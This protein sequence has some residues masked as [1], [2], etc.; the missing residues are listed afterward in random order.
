M[1]PVS[2]TARERAAATHA[3]AEATPAGPET[4]GPGAAGVELHPV[5]CRL[6]DAL[7]R[8]LL[9][10]TL[11]RIPSNPAAPTGDVD[12]LVA[13]ADAAALRDVA[14]EHGFVP[15]PGW[16]SSPDLILVCYDRPSDR[17]LLLD[18]STAVSFRSPPSWRI[19]GAAEQVLGRR[20]RLDGMT[21]PD[22]GDAFWLLLLHC[23]L[24]KGRVA[25]GH[26]PR[27]QSLA[28]AGLESPLGPALCSAAGPRFEPAVF[29]AAVRSGEW[30]AI[31]ALGSKL[32]VDLRR[33]RRVRERLRLMLRRGF[34]S[35]RKP[36]LMR[37]RRGLN[38][39]LLGPNGVGKSTAAAGLQ[40][41]FP[42]ESRI[43]YMGMWKA[44]AGARGPVSALVEILVRPL[45]I[46][47]R[48]LVAQYHQLRGRLVVFDRYVYEALLPAQPPL[49]A[50]K[51]PYFWCLAHALPAAGAVIVLDVPGQVAYGRKQENLPDELESE[52]QIYA[53]LTGR[54]PSLELV[55][56]GADADTV[57]AEITTIVWRQLTARWQGTARRR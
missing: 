11:L 6:F 21:V 22:D 56:A 50:L 41:S 9:P 55:D 52:R 42:F 4:D 37:R 18:V 24:D 48:Y 23:L 30:E 14:A 29:V 10:W 38:L 12:L 26:R 8:R 47:S 17:W 32:A 35:A 19:P 54:V 51:R 20:R 33:R 27:L 16:E 53:Q 43:V 31:T 13:P 39:A 25:D 46:W 44:A 45:R 5:L 1:N 7:E 3:R 15:L 40:R 36:L 49:L 57:R 34:R 28:S 2:Q